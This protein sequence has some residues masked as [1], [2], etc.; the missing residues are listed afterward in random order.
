MEK[1]NLYI[2]QELL[3][4]L[5]I[6]PEEAISYLLNKEAITINP[7]HVKALHVLK[8]KPAVQTS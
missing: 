8:E 1:D 4:K 7:V 3:S 6:D 2:T 5:G